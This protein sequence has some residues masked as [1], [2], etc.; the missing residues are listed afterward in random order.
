MILVMLTAEIMV[1][2]FR[3]VVLQNVLNEFSTSV[4]EQT[5]TNVSSLLLSPFSHIFITPSFFTLSPII[6][7][8]PIHTTSK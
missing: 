5:Q 6:L 2:P 3:Q 4:L 8:I 1:T 7:L